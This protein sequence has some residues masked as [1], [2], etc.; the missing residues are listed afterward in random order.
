MTF[1]QKGL[2]LAFFSVWRSS[3]I[4]TQDI[5]W[6]GLPSSPDILTSSTIFTKMYN[7]LL[8]SLFFQHASAHLFFS[9]IF[10]W[11][12]FPALIP[13]HD[14]HTHRFPL[15]DS[16]QVSPLCASPDL[17]LVAELIHH[18]LRPHVQNHIFVI[19]LLHML[20]IFQTICFFCYSWE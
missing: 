5:L 18:S 20:W 12:D 15:E 17:C 2:S 11:Q 13:I 14:C 4:P 7:G 3:V 1:P 9:A 16:A 8:R 19:M 10:V 6:I